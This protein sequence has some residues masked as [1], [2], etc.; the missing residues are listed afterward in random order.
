MSSA[1][2]VHEA[3]SEPEVAQHARSVAQDPVGVPPLLA[4]PLL[5][6]ELPPEL[7]PLPLPEPPLLEVTP[8]WLAQFAFSHELSGEMA[9]VQDGSCS[10]DRHCW[11]LASL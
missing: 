1:V 2:W 3:W 11:A 7:L 4:P 8:H 9:F 10:L 6:P 5:L